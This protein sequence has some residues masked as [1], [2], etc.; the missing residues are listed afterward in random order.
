MMDKKYYIDVLTKHAS[1]NKRPYEL[2]LADFLDYLLDA[3]SVD[4]FRDGAHGYTTYQ[5]AM[6]ARD[7][8][9]FLLGMQWLVDVEASMERGQWL[10]AFGTLYE[11]LYLT[12][13]KASHTGQFFT[14]RPISDLCAAV[15]DLP[16]DHGIVNDCAAGSGRLLLS[17]YMERTRED[18]DAGRAFDYLA[19]D[20]DPTACK[21]CALNMMVHGMRGRVVCQDTLAMST[22][23]VVYH[24]NEVRYPF[25][26]PY[27]SVRV[28]LPAP[29]TE[30]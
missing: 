18:R 12:R 11:D 21:M 27:Y 26:S 30:Q 22:P 13:G 19:Q 23:A 6:Y 17:H 29:E 14:P 24:L 1:D 15:I 4:A 25:P 20:S 28:Q 10:D 16:R 2:A 8:A 9:F 7:P 5:R 3:F